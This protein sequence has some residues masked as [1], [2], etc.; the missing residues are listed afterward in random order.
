[1]R[2]GQTKLT[3]T[4][5]KELAFLLFSYLLVLVLYLF[6]FVFSCGGDV[7]GRKNGKNW[8]MY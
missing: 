6:I 2:K 7:G 3:K 8:T 1:M 4:E 5:E